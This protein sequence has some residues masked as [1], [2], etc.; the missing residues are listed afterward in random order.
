MKIKILISLVLSILFIGCANNTPTH[1]IQ[2]IPIKPK[3]YTLNITTKPKNAKIEFEYLNKKY[4]PNMK[5]KA[6]EYLIKVSAKFYN[7]EY[8]RIYLN[9]NKNIF[10]SLQSKFNIDKEFNKKINSLAHNINP[11]SMNFVKKGDVV[12]DKDRKLMWQDNK[13]LNSQK[14]MNWQQ[15]RKY[16]KNLKLAGHKDWRLP[17]IQELSTI[18]D[19]DRYNPAIAKEF[20]NVKSDWYWTNTSCASNSNDAW[21]L[22]FKYGSDYHDYK[23]SSAYVRC[24][25]KIK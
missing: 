15:A 9:S 10:I 11:N 14:Q 19:L 4:K 24:V 21:G 23:N 22:Y 8:K 12:I 13:S 25:R 3:Y 5:L 17:T 1:Q 18:I 7:P 16:C 6:G 20:K 2:L